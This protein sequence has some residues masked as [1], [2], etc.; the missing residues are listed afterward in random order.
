M[1]AAISTIG[2]QPIDAALL[3]IE[4]MSERSYE[5]AERLQDLHIPFTF[6]SG[7]TVR[8]LPPKMRDRPVLTKPVERA[9]LLAAVQR[10]FPAA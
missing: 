9:L 1:N 4:L 2:E 8:E 10:M 6:L 3:D 7:H 5:V